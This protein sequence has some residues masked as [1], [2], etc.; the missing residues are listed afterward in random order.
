MIPINDEYARSWHLGKEKEKDNYIKN[1]V[2]SPNQ[3]SKR[4]EKKEKK[5]EGKKINFYANDFYQWRACKE[6]LRGE[7]S[8]KKKG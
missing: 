1:S 2:S 5:E 3:K 8:R 4:K 6:G 7:S